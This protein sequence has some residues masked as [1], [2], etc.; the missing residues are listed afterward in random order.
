MIKRGQAGVLAP[1]K[2]P[3]PSECLP[4]SEARASTV[5]PT[6]ASTLPVF[7]VTS[8]RAILDHAAGDRPILLGSD[9][10]ASLRE[11][12]HPLEGPMPLPR[13][14]R[15]RPEVIR[16]HYQRE[17]ATEPDILVAA[18]A[19]T[20]AHALALIGMSFR[21]AALTGQAI[22]LAQEAANAADR[23]ILVAAAL[24]STW[25]A[26]LAREAEEIELS[27]ARL[28]ASG[29]ALVLISS[30]AKGVAERRL[31]EGQALEAARR[32]GLVAWLVVPS[33]GADD[34]APATTA[35]RAKEAGATA[36]LVRATSGDEAQHMV[37]AASESG[38]IPGVLLAAPAKGTCSAWV[39][40]ASGL[41]DL[42]ARILGGGDGTTHRHIA[43]LASLLGVRFP[44]TKPASANL[45]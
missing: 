12:G 13:L 23:E 17:V 27:A 20:T 41:A 21:A 10:V 33:A 4:P 45:G 9:P 34:E 19:D 32:A 3:D 35:A 42:G 7:Q 40:E 30:H 26:S 1:T 6:N 16:A 18:T 15:E 2:L 31:A 22:E 44:A 24:G 43:A 25:P 39:R 29:C 11:Q 5:V 28:Q 38:L 14:L 37:E 8:L 36:L